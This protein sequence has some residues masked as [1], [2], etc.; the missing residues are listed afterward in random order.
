MYEQLYHPCFSLVASVCCIICTGAD[1]TI[2]TKLHRSG[3]T[4]HFVTSRCAVALTDSASPNPPL[5]IYLV[6][7]IWQS[8]L[9]Y[10]GR[11]VTASSVPVNLSR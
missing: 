8:S 11:A 4:C 2:S 10:H 3:L 5:V 1:S 9:C 7:R 6:E